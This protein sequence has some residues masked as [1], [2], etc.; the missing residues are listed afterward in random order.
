MLQKCYSMYL[1]VIT[2]DI[3]LHLMCIKRVREILLILHLNGF[4]L[5][6]SSSSQYIQRKNTVK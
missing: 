1:W 6:E 5:F 2:N 3:N 4:I